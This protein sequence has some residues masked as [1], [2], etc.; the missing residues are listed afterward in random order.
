[1]VG[2]TP[3]EE[4]ISRTREAVKPLGHSESTLWHYDYGWEQLRRFHVER[5]T[6]AFSVDLANEHVGEVRQRY[7]SGAIKIWK[8]KLTRRCVAYLIQFYES[9][10]I[11]WSQLPRWGRVGIK[12]PSYLDMAHQY[13]QH[14][15]DRAY[16]QGTIEFYRLTADQLLSF[17]EDRH[18][19]NLEQWTLGEISRFI[20]HSSTHHQ[21]TSMRTVLSALRSFLRFVCDSG[22][23]TSDLT[24]AVPQ[25]SG[26]RTTLV[27][28]ITADEEKRLLAA[29]DRR[30][31]VG[32]RD[33]AMILLALRLGLR[34]IDIVKLKLE[35]IDW[36]TSTI[37]IV[38]KK[39]GRRL[40]TPLLGDVGNALIDYLVN[41]RPTSSPPY[42]FL[43]NSAPYVHLS[44]SSS[45]YY[46]VASSMR[47]ARIRQGE[48]EN[49][50]AHCLR[51]SLAARLLGAETPLPIIS[52]IL[53]HA[54][55][56][57]TRIYLSSDIEHL[58]AC[59][60]SLEGIEVGREVLS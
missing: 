17:L 10:V 30:S 31:A 32:K 55:K 59:A 8:F 26:R 44:Q 13:E 12:T 15:W 24:R 28:T 45:V 35:N 58:R 54:N 29:I 39:T 27:P 4:L 38:Q 60:L 21:P 18:V 51:H 11:R 50:G 7:E 9:G 57:S 36:R 48:K 5:G 52:G 20:S 46:A 49:R 43:R 6:D 53:G 34:S 56:E 3:L 42:V 16:G 47:I 19:C 41:S 1:M 2:K 22:S 23:A 25:S 37:T 14:L 40:V 33:F